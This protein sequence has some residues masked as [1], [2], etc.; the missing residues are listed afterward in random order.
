M[1]TESSAYENLVAD[2]VTPGDLDASDLY[3][4]ITTSGRDVMPPSSEDPL[5]AEQIDDV[6]LWITEGALP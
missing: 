2:Y 5:T 4:K 3:E 6:A 1:A